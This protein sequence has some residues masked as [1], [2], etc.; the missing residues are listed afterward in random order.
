MSTTSSTNSGGFVEFTVDPSH[1]FYVHPSDSPG[2]QLVT[3]PFNGTGFVHW[4][5]SMLTSLSAK[6]KL[7]LIKGKIAQ[8]HTDSPYYP[9]W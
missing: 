6:N 5:N 1:P 2:S 3:I 4:C 9:F 8:P 7:G